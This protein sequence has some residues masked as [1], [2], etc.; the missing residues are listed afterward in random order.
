MLPPERAIWMLAFLPVWILLAKLAG[1]YDAD[2]RAMRHLTVDEAPAIIAWGVFGTVAVGL[3]G[4]LTPAGTL[5]TG[6]LAVV[7]GSRSSPTSRCGSPR[8]PSGGRP[9]RASGS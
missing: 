8:G 5:D 2:H 6:E 7:A 9:R 1:L 3:L 4:G